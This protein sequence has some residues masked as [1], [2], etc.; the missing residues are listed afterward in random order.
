MDILVSGLG[1]GIH[2]DVIES[3]TVTQLVERYLDKASKGC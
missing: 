1:K 3:S 2:M